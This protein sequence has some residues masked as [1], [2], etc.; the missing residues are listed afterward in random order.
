MYIKQEVG[1]TSYQ[2]WDGL[3][4]FFFE[5]IKN[6]RVLSKQKSLNNWQRA[7]WKYF[8]NRNFLP[9]PLYFLYFLVHFL[10]QGGLVT[11]HWFSKL[12]KFWKWLPKISK[13]FAVALFEKGHLK[14]FLIKFASIFFAIRFRW[15]HKK[16][17]SCR[18][19]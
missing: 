18:N 17:I 1:R 3:K 2:T 11:S 13:N 19:I 6:N 16:K 15:K 7:C 4:C 5:L 14:I 8:F 9:D 10:Y 12:Q